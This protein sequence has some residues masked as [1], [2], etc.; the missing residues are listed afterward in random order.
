MKLEHF[1]GQTRK[2]INDAGITQLKSRFKE[3]N[4]PQKE[5]D[6]QTA[7]PPPKKSKKVTKNV[8]HSHRRHSH[9]QR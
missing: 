2:L 8:W 6:D 3:K 1:S 7:Q 9:R 4:S 5:A